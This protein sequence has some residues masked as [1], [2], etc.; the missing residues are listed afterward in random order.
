MS[1]QEQQAGKTTQEVIESVSEQ[2]TDVSYTDG[3]EMMEVLGD[4]V[5]W[6]YDNELESEMENLASFTG[7]TV[8]EQL[9]PFLTTHV[10]CNKETP[11]LRSILN[12]LHAKNVH[13]AQNTRKAL[14]ADTT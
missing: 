9:V 8:L 5:L 3:L 12:A 6:A 1:L 14:S 7:A 4:V 10:V 11:Q 13:G 2:M